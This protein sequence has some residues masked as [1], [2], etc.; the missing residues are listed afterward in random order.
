MMREMRAKGCRLREI[1]DRAGSTERTV[2]RTLSVAGRRRGGSRPWAAQPL[3][4]G[5]GADGRGRGGR[6]G[7]HGL[8]P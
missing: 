2:R 5:G 8:P 1:A 7:T 4:E 6:A 3:P